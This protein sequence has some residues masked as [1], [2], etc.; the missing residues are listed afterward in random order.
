MNHSSRR[1]R[2][3]ISLI[4]VAIATALAIPA[5]PIAGSSAASPSAAPAAAPAVSGLSFRLHPTP[6]PV[7]TGLG[8]DAT[9]DPAMDSSTCGYLAFDGTDIADTS[10]LKAELYSE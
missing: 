4:T 1:R 6:V 3:R 7:C 9:A 5:L 10:K 8:L 2:L